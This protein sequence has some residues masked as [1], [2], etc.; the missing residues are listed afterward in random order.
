MGSRLFFCGM[1]KNMEINIFA[2]CVLSK[3][4]KDA[5]KRLF[6]D[7]FERVGGCPQTII[8]D[9]QKAIKMAL[10]ELKES[11]KFVGVY[12]LDS[13][14]LLTNVKKAGGRKNLQIYKWLIKSKTGQ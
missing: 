3:E 2:V 5:F 6:V 10:S 7:F 12:L 1:G 13:F 8:S 4:T 14:H 9:E 11:N